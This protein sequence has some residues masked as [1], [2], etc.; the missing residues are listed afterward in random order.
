[1]SLFPGK[2]RRLDERSDKRAKESRPKPR[3]KKPGRRPRRSHIANMAPAGI[4]SACHPA[5]AVH[6]QNNASH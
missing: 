1:M 2:T 3:N 5:A 4:E 6:F